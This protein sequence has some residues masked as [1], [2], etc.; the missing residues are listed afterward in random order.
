MSDLA[1]TEPR[2]GLPSYQMFM[3]A[4]SIVA[5]GAILAQNAFRLDPQIELILEYADLAI[6]AAFLLDFFVTLW[7]APDR[8]RYLRTWGW[9]DLISS[10]PTLDVARWGRLARVARLLRILRALRATRL[11]SKV[12]LQQRRQSTSFA[13]AFVA[14]LLILGAS[15]AILHFETAPESNIKSAGDAVWWAFTTITTVGYGDRFPISTAGR[16]V[17]CL[18]MT[19]GVGLFGVFSASLAAWFLVP[20]DEAAEGEIAALRAEIAA[21]RESIESLRAT[22]SRAPNS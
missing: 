15:T 11:L 22:P 19:A 21:L 18:L 16:V 7:R 8:W 9:I 3:L 20:E 1:V 14:F 13:A 4:L 10:I 6:C 17:A 5:L 2:G 12:M